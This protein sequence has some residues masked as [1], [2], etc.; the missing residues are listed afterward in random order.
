M[1]DVLFPK[2]AKVTCELK[3][4][5][6]SVSWQTE[7]GTYG[8]AELPRS[9]SDQPSEYKSV[10]GIDTWSDFK[11]YAVQ[12]TPGRFIFRGQANAQRLRTAFHR[13]NRKDLIKFMLQDIPALH[14]ALSA[15]TK[16]VSNLSDGLQNGAFWN[17]IQ[18]HGYPTP[19][20][21]WSESPFV[22]AFFAFR[23]DRYR[24]SDGEFVRVF[25]FDRNAWRNDYNQLQKVAPAKPHF[26]I[27]EALAIE[28]QRA[29]PQQ[30]LSSVTNVDDIETYIRF[31]EM[32]RATHYLRVFD[33]PY[34]ERTSIL[35]ELGMMGITAG[36]LFPGLD[37]AC[38][39][40]RARFFGYEA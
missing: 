6:L 15:Q 1:P 24:R 30:A 23:A 32:E 34:T 38:E 28:N 12:L 7:I 4:E 26:S 16:H 35:G 33:L 25:M 40:L 14:R 36:S 17:L 13:T 10:E 39:G 2:S 21:D 11:S 19:L 27:L 22:A 18:H 3:N 9:K 8:S 20:L 37:G 29:L 5:M 31:R